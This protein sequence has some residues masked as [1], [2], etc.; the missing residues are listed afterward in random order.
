MFEIVKVSL[1]QVASGAPGGSNLT[2]MS[3]IQ[4]PIIIIIMN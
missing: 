2:D 1:N 3:A 4:E